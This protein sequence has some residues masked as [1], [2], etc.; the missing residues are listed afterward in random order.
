[1]AGK[2]ALLAA[3]LG[4][5]GDT[6]T[7]GRQVTGREFKGP[8]RSSLGL[9]LLYTLIEVE[10]HWRIWGRGFLCCDLTCHLAPSGRHVE[11]RL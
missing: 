1:M 7:E 9:G 8:F 3:G 6:G 11:C 5:E 4:G 2:P 10:N